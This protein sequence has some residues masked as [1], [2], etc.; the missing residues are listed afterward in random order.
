M[1][2]DATSYDYGA[3]HVLNIAIVCAIVSIAIYSDG[4]DRDDSL[5]IVNKS[6]DFFLS[7]ALF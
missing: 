4:G 1:R 7:I 2:S 5:T 6:S 3:L